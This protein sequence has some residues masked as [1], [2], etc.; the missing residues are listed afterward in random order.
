MGHFPAS[1]PRT[2]RAAVTQSQRS[3]EDVV[4]GYQLRNREVRS[5]L[6][7]YLHRR[8]STVDYSTLRHLTAN[9]VRVFWKTVEQVNPDQ[10]DR[11][12][13]EET[14]QKWK[15][16][17]ATTCNGKP[18]QHLEGPLLAVRSFYLDLQN[19]AHAEP[20]RWARWVAPCPIRDE[21]LRG[22]VVALLVITRR[23][24]TGNASS[25]CLPS[26]ST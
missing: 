5:L 14:F 8:A 23:R 26:C 17:I 19:W 25:P 22:E 7:E 1:A 24:A 11:H 18:R 16:A 2:L 15:A 21:D 9:L 10:A 13:S 20:E 4:D 3:I 6:V 12:L